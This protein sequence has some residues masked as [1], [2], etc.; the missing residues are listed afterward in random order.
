[1]TL[2][3]A[4]GAAAAMLVAALLAACAAPVGLPTSEADATAMREHPERMIVLA[5]AN[6]TDALPTQAGS[7]VAGYTLAPPYAAGGQ[8]RALLAD[9]ARDYGL[10]EVAGWPIAALRLH[11]VVLRVP[12]GRSR[13]E[14]LAAL[15]K[16]TRVALAQPLQAFDTYGSDAA[17]NDPYVGL[18]RG[19]Q[20]VDAAEAHQRSRGKGVRIAIVDT[21]ADIGHPDLAGRVDAARNFVDR[22]AA[23]FTRDRHGT[24]VAGVI[25]AIANNR[26]GIVGIAPEAQVTVLKACWEAG[27][28]G[29][30]RCNSFTLAQA[31]AAGLA[32]GA[33]IINLSLGGPPDELLTRLVA[34]ALQRG[35][36]VVGALPPDGSL[37]GFPVNVPG[38]I[39]VG[40]PDA[41]SAAALH[42]P[43]RDIL[44]LQPG[45]RY[46][47]GSGSSLAAA[48]VSAAAAL[49]LA[50]EPGL[51]APRVRALL[52]AS[53]P[54][55][56]G[57]GSINAC[58]ALAALADGLPCAARAAQGPPPAS[59][60][61]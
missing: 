24:E 2:R 10:A 58:V 28:L 6:P 22:D 41:G 8:A 40:V 51:D 34:L 33:Q 59:R 49:L 44:T 53:Q 17:Y 54:G 35:R 13:D 9:V 37:A 21:G 55:E 48:H 11:C 60:S 46:D 18:Q 42:A 23:Q 5:V 25:A 12:D 30:A 15:G 27:P 3:R 20:E 31:L 50:A 16:D 47:F 45:G 57:T 14:L 19:F 4:L 29:G 7:T 39:A 26:Q 56:R 1:V 43:G 32:D 36:I 61:P 52:V 38:V